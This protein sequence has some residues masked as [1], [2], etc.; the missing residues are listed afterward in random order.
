MKILS[1]NQG[2]HDTSSAFL[3]DNKLVFT[4]EAEKD[5]GDRHSASF[6]P[7]FLVNSFHIDNPPDVLAFS[8]WHKK[9]K[10]FHAN[11]DPGYFGIGTDAR[12]SFS[13]KMLGSSIKVFAS[14]HERSHIMCSYGLSPF[15][16]GQPCYALVWEGAIGAFY[17][18]DSNVEITK[19]GDVLN[20]PGNRY[21][22]L[23]ALADPTIPIWSDIVRLSDAGKLMALAAYGS[24]TEATFDEQQTIK[25]IMKQK[26]IYGV[27]LK[28]KMKESR[29]FNIG[30]ESQEF[31]NLAQR[32]S[33]ALFE[34]FYTFAKN[35]VKQKIPLLISGGCGLNCDWNSMWKNSGLFS[36]VFVP[37]CT[38]DSGVALG[39]AI[40]AL[41]YYIGNA[42]IEWDV[43][44]GN[45]FFEDIAITDSCGFEEHPLDLVKLSKYL[46]EGKIFAWV[47]EELKWGRGHLETDR[48]WLSPLEQK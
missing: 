4:H 46:A 39:A 6:P 8:C 36:D 19:I 38:N 32:F 42:K 35:N 16:Q 20:E 28:Y 2:H 22:F 10:Q 14:S 34:T 18:I 17:Y 7:L 23:Y 5:S 29:Y 21:A 44:N 13:E 11:T 27:K 9:S 47:Q 1:F 26:L 40:D 15:P 24:N 12:V 37:P 45:N 3:D 41:F 33:D 31:K 30:L 48:Y 25:Y 43:Y